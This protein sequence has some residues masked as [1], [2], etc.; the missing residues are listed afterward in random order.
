MLSVR[1]LSVI[2]LLLP[3]SVFAGID[4]YEFSTEEQRVRY[5][6]FIE[7]LRCPKCKN[8]NL[9][10]TNS[11]IAVDLRRQ[12]QV[13]IKE[14]QSDEQIVDY[15]VTRYGDFVLYRPRF[16]SKT[17]ALWLGPLVFLTAGFIT[18]GTIVMMRR[19]KLNGNAPELSEQE[20]L[21]LQRLLKAEKPSDS[22]ID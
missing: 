10:G 22:S 17:I 3:F 5:S 12:L 21:A 9:A 14:D 16:T 20:S 7:E 18:I 2:L 4:V 11:K 8:N 19:R 15:M 6:T 1:F 13:M